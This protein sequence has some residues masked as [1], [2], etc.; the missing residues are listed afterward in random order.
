[1]RDEIFGPVI[2]V[3]T[4]SSEDEVIQQA[5]DTQYGLAAAVH[6]KDYERAIRMTNALQAGT[7]WVNMYNLVHYSL[8]F[9]G[10]KQSGIGRECGEAALENYTAT[11]AV[12]FNTGF[13]CPK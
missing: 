7:T 6:T 10:F 1:M 9:G 3:C 11:K 4:F 2:C 13:P 12:Y 8:D 5:N